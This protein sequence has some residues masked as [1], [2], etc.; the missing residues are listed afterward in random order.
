MTVINKI[1]AIL[2]LCALGLTG[3]VIAQESFDKPITINVAGTSGGGL[4]LVA[5]LLSR[6]LGRHVPGKPNVIVQNMPGAG[7]IRAANYLAD[8]APRD[9]S[10]W[11]VFAG[12]P[13]IEP[14]IGARNPGYDMS[15]F[16]WIG[17]TTKD[18]GLC[19]AIGT[20][21][22]KTVE[23]ARAREMVVAGTGAGSETDTYPI[24]LNEVLKTKFK[25]ITGY[26]GTKETIMAMENGEAHG[27][28]SFALSAI[29]ITRPEWLRDKKLNI[30]FQ[31]AMEKSPELP[32]APLVFDYLDNEADRQLMELMVATKAI[33]LPF[34][35][36]PGVPSARLETLRRAFDATVKDP[37]F[38]ADAKKM[39]LDS[40]PTTGEETQ[41]I[42]A[43]LYQT[44]PD[45]VERAKKLLTP[46]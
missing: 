12:G 9:G 27:R 24:V 44:P 7:G 17:A 20:S 10:V 23:D 28:C 3:P 43:K 32:D 1:A 22:F 34:A 18:F 25:L 26:L 40:D 41:K 46:Q 19:V 8:S 42:I 5:R 16:N 29:K 13:I 39:L 33:A 11:A 38:L 21:G 31:L 4:D 6:H 35:A 14:L 30:L 45:V 37:E 2:G 36:P 15:K